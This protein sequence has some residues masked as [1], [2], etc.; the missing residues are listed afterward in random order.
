MR[1]M[2]RGRIISKLDLRTN[3]R[4]GV[5]TR[6]SCVGSVIW[7][8]PEGE[9]FADS[10]RSRRTG[11]RTSFNGVFTQDT[12]AELAV[13]LLLVIAMSDV[14]SDKPLDSLDDI[15]ASLAHSKNEIA[16]V[17]DRLESLLMEFHSINHEP[18]NTLRTDWHSECE[19]R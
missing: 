10:S 16:Y 14:V 12:G 7:C 15:S 18:S 8:S 9:P 5:A 1:W 17:H 6:R 11:C 13:F 3:L 19:G 2:Q 4:R